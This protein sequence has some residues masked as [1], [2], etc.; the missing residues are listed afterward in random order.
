MPDGQELLQVF[1]LEK[2][3]PLGSA[4]FARPKHWVR[5]VDGVS[6][7]IRSGET[8]G[9]VGESG[10]GK[11]T[12]GRCIL[13]LTEPTSG[14]IV[15]DGV[16]L[17]ALRPR[18]MRAMRR[19]LQVIFQDP[20]A[21]LDPRMTIGA[22]VEEPLIIHRV[23]SRPERKVKVR[24]LLE[25]VG[26]DPGFASRYPHEFS[27]GQR[28]RVG[29]ARALA[30]QPK[31]IVAD[32]PVS[33]LDVSVQAQIVNLLQVLQRRHG[34][35]YLFISHGMAVVQHICTRVGV[36]YLGKLVELG[37]TEALFERPLHPYTQV[38]RSSIPNPDPEAG[39]ERIRPQADPPATAERIPGCPFHP[40]CPYVMEECRVQEPPLLEIRPGHKVACFLATSA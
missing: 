25:D 31:F 26:L 12:T 23:G 11:T 29:I 1:D 21:S 13:R 19:H 38:L 34:L 14:R 28:Q 9:L 33:A 4:L 37:E 24:A 6:F 2:H 15:F 16:D 35:T 10:S 30:L 20:Y 17:L 5:A 8:L 3:Y 27:G 40:R 32:E 36:M 39:R 18:E 7:S 22:S